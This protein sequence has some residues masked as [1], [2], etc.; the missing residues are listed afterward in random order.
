M[1]AQ[2]EPPRE[3][4]SIIVAGT[5]SPVG[6]KPRALPRLYVFM[7]YT[8]VRQA[9]VRTFNTLSA[10][11]RHR[12]VLFTAP[13]RTVHDSVA[14]LVRYTVSRSM[15]V[16]QQKFDSVPSSVRKPVAISSTVCFHQFDRLFS[17]VRQA[18]GLWTDG[19]HSCPP[20]V[21]DCP[22]PGSTGADRTG[23][24]YGRAARYSSFTLFQSTTVKYSFI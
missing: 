6:P 23:L 4:V 14:A 9:A 1:L 5:A 18:V 2:L 8:P 21:R 7:A 24:P 11:S 22:H 3:Y 19:V 13:Y 20:P 12:I 10:L 15:T 16:C 17:E